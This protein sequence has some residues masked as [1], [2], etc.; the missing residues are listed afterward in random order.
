[1]A[2]PIKMVRPTAPASCW[3]LDRKGCF[4]L[5]DSQRQYVT[6]HGRKARAIIAYLAAHPGERISRERL[7]ELLWSDRGEAQARASLRQ[8][9]VE[10]R[11]AARGLILSDHDYVWI[12]R[13]RLEEDDE[14]DRCVADEQLFDDL[15]DITPEFDAWLRCVRSGE[16]AEEWSE[17]KWKAEQRLGR[18]EPDLAMPLIDR[19]RALDPFNEDWLRLAM[20]AERQA[21]HPAGIQQRFLAMDE[22]LKRELGVSLSAQTRTLR[23]RLLEELSEPEPEAVA[24]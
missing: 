12:E 14:W 4:V 3:R 21:G 23:D 13:A 18:E 8:A 1:M 22:L 9:L 16:A 24:R 6:L 17:L 5:R 7:I 15:D 19:M 11:R 2:T 10:I 20:Q